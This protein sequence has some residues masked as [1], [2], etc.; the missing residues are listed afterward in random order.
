MGY[1]P[2]QQRVIACNTTDENW[3][4]LWLRNIFTRVT[5]SAWPTVCV[6]IASF[7][8]M[9][10]FQVETSFFNKRPVKYFSINTKSSEVLHFISCSRSEKI[11]GDAQCSAPTA[12][13]FVSYATSLFG[14]LP[15]AKMCLCGNSVHKLISSN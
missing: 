10:L 1:S 8:R 3:N 11:S 13:L 12:R 4:Q 7:S 2:D 15:D 14:D 9:I 6:S 5:P